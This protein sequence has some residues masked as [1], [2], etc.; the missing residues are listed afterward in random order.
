MLGDI[1]F[2]VVTN[3]TNYHN[4]FVIDHDGLLYLLIMTQI[5]IDN[6]LSWSIYLR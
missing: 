2:L 5:D 3:I 6:N 1:L 4:L